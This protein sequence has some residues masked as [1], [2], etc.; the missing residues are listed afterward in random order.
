MCD[1]CV[2]DLC[3]CSVCCM[4]A[5]CVVG[6]VCVL[7]VVK[8]CVMCVCVCSVCSVCSVCCTSGLDAGRMSQAKRHFQKVVIKRGSIL[9]GCLKR[10]CNFL[11]ICFKIIK[12]F[13][14]LK[15]LYLN[16]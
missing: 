3:V 5:L 14:F 2:R 16:V 13:V 11:K 6:V 8:L 10:N 15:A 9:G 7:C 4:R 12:S 1:V